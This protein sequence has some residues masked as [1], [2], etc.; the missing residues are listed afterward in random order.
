MQYVLIIHEVKDY[1][2][3]KM[4]FD[5]AAGL[6]RDA[7]EIEYQVLKYELDPNKVVH[8]SRW[9]SHEHAKKFFQ[10]DEVEDIRRKA[11]VKAPEFI[12]LDLLEAGTR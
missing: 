5:N 1:G 10:S 8:F 6:L 11:G 12:Y 3:W 2:V 7:G 4:A 9:K